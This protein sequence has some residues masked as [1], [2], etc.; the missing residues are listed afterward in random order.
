MR[1]APRRTKG[2]RR[3]VAMEVVQNTECPRTVCLQARTTTPNRTRPFVA[4]LSAQRRQHQSS[5]G[6]QTF[7]SVLTHTTR[8]PPACLRLQMGGCRRN[9]TLMP[10]SSLTTAGRSTP[11]ITCPWI[12]GRLS[13]N[14]RRR[15]H[16]LNRVHGRHHQVHSQCRRAAGD[17]FALHVHRLCQ[18]RHLRQATVAMT[19]RHTHLQH[20]SAPVEIAYRKRHTE[21]RQ[22]TRRLAPAPWRRSR[23]TTTKTGRVP[24]ARR[25]VQHAAALG[26]IRARTTHLSIITMGMR[27]LPFQ[28]RC[29]CPR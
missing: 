15:S 22:H 17:P 7:L 21:V 9:A 3:L 6:Y 25:E 10:R 18:R 28:P 8:S 24:T 19:S 14:Q 23:Q 26:T 16:H 5:A 12:P 29:R 1:T 13:R 4:S 27:G 2:D 20:Q 11:L